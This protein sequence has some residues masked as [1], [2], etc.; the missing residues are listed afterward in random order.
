MQAKKA[1]MMVYQYHFTE[2]PDH[3][4][5][6]DPGLVLGL[7]NEVHLKHESVGLNSPIVV[8]CRYSFHL[9]NIWKN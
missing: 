9:S 6:E 2:W 8:H 5:S 7:L 3:G 4:V 1:P